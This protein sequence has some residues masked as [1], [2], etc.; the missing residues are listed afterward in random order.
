MLG[1]LGSD[2]HLLFLKGICSDACLYCQSH[3]D[4]K[5]HLFCDESQDTR[6]GSHLCNF[7]KTGSIDWKKE[8][9]NG[10]YLACFLCCKLLA[11]WLMEKASL[12][13]QGLQLA[14]FWPFV[15]HIMLNSQQVTQGQL[16]TVHGSA[17]RAVTASERGC[18]PACC[19]NDNRRALCLLA[20]AD[21]TDS[22]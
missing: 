12:G 7:L 8:Q 13:E 11:T 4:T 6:Q 22:I 5:E 9:F 16:A 14:S 19:S 18:A 21:C 15:S 10:C 17:D 20:S 2:S 3:H 1:A